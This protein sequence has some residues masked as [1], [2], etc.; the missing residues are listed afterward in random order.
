MAGVLREG[1]KG[2]W[3]MV[4]IQGI[5]IAIVLPLACVLVFFPLILVT[6][7]EMNIWWLIIPAFLFL[8]ILLGGSIGVL[9]YVLYK[10]TRRLDEVITPLGLN[11]SPYGLFYRQYAGSLSGRDVALFTY[12]GPTMEIDLST[13]LQTRI[14]IS[15]RQFD[16]LALGSIMNQE[17]LQLSDPDLRDLVVYA[18]DK[19]W[20]QRFLAHPQVPVLLQRLIRTETSFS[21]LLVLL[22]PGW[23]HLRAWGSKNWL[24]FTF[25][26]TREQFN[27]WVRDLLALLEIAESLPTPIAAVPATPAEQTARSLRTGISSKTISFTIGMVVVMVVSWR[28]YQVGSKS[29]NRWAAGLGA[30]LLCSQVALVTH[31]LVDAVTWGMVRP[32]P[33]V[34]VVWGLAASGAGLFLKRAAGDQPG[35]RIP[36]ERSQE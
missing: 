7:Q 34:W 11:G 2:C 13:S 28:I 1:H 23:L 14:G 4:T 12:R 5:A 26:I 24:D 20:T 16:T 33:L 3:R 9:S 27:A 36:A 19:D 6:R 31:G 30:G 15:A 29:G 22:R 25:D 18:L 8:V 21:S 32:A 35:S 10:R 17:A